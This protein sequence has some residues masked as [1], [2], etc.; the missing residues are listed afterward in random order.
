[1]RTSLFL[2]AVLCGVLLS[3]CS[4]NTPPP[5]GANAGLPEGQTPRQ[6][7]N[8]FRDAGPNYP[9]TGR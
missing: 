3:A 5:Q 7:P 1:M 4:Y 9:D 6:V 2:A 8:S